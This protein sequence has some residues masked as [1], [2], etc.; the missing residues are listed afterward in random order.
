MTAQLHKL[1]FNKYNEFY[2]HAD[3]TVDPAKRGHI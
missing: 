2:I 1:I 3:K